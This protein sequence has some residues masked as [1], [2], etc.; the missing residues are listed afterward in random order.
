[1]SGYGQYCPVAKAAEVFA[2]RW[3]PLVIRELLAGSTHFND[4]HRGIPL[5]SRTLLSH[6][7]K[8][9]ETIGV[10]RRKRG[11]RGNEYHLTAAGREFAPLVHLLGEWG[12][13][14]FR[15]SFEPDELD[16]GVLAWEMRRAVRLDVFP[17]G[18]VNVQLDFPDQPAAK[19]HWWLVSDG[20]SVD[21]CPINPGFEVDLLVTADLKTLARVWMGDLSAKGAVAAGK[22]ELEGAH[23]F[24]R[25]FEQWL[26][27][28]CYAGV[29]SA[30]LEV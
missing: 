21:L 18:R 24:R 27:L 8:R 23:E 12:H 9:L 16:A 29:K 1:L 7:L 11:E 28:S 19:R 26:S 22:I 10:V 15:S 5:M 4:I 25:C 2:E 13:R 6:R 3:T 17:P 30:R 20:G 14:W